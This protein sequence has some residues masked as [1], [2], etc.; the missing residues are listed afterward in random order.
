M[1]G[2]SPVT[3]LFRLSA[4]AVAAGWLV[5]AAALAVQEHGAP[6]GPLRPPVRP[7][8]FPGLHGV[9][10]LLA[11]PAA[12]GETGRMALH[13]V[14][15][16]SSSFSGTSM[17]S[18]P[19]CLTNNW[20]WWTFSASPPGRSASMPA[21]CPPAL[22]WLYYAAKLDHL[23]CVPALLFLYFGLR[24]LLKEAEA[25]NQRGRPAMIAPFAPLLVVDVGGSVLMIVF[26]LPV[27]RAGAPPAAAGPAQR[28]LDLSVLG[29]LRH[30]PGSPSPGR[31][32]TSSSRPS[33][34]PTT[35]KPGPAIRPFSGAI[36]TFMFV[37]VA[38]VTLFFERVWKSLR[39]DRGG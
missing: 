16:A 11:A 34:S 17:R 32:A 21:T 8:V 3:R 4:L 27:P 30:W 24:R 9:A 26:L 19:T 20:T 39:A 22:A 29:V 13:P 1:H 15:G 2:N 18:R 35:R 28:R 6:E 33:C 23:L 7:S 14:R 5:P 36:N 12:A 38:S 37:F 10:D 31:P 25:R